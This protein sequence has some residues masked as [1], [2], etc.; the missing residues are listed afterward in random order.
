LDFS[1]LSPVLLIPVPIILLEAGPSQGYHKFFRDFFILLL[2]IYLFI[3][4]KI[5]QAARLPLRRCRLIFKLFFDTST[6]L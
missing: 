3:F 6:I 4:Q 5:V 1:V 2:F